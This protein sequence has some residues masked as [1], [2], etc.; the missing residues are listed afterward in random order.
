MMGSHEV[1]HDAYS[2]TDRTLGDGEIEMVNSR[3]SE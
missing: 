1:Q 2:Y 3:F